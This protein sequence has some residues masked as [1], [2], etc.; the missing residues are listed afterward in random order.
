MKQNTKDWIQHLA[1]IALVLASIVMGFLAFILTKDIGSGP[2]T[3]IAES[4]SAALA[5]FG[6]GVFV[7]N[8][9]GEVRTVATNAIRKMQAD[10]D[11]EEDTE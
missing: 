1:A 5:L 11:T 9:V 7:N 4:L 8:K 2:L 3:Y 10:T 6:I